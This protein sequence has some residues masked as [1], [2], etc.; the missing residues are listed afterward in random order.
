MNKTKKSQFFNQLADIKLGDH[1]CLIY[2]TLSEQFS[3]IIPFI[4]IG[5][6]RNEKCI[7]VADDNTTEAVIKAMKLDDSKLFLSAIKKGNLLLLTK[8][9]TYLKDG[10]FS[11][12]KMVAFIKKT[13]RTAIK[14]GYT[15]L[16][17]TGEMTWM[18]GGDPGSEKLI[19]Y[20]YKLNDFFEEYGVCAI[21][22]YNQKRFSEE[23]LVDVFKTHPYV[24]Y[25]KKIIQNPIYLSDE[26]FSSARQKML[27]ILKK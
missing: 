14:N 9:E 21:C 23:L 20:E 22:Q 13:A 12:K 3:S 25:G 18:F 27:K 10:Y 4:K 24:I 8:N 19:E 7:Y 6:D 5:L 15:G 1:L 11:P 2:N 26:E 16:R 17:I